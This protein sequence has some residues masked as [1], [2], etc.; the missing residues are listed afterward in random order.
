MQREFQGFPDERIEELARRLEAAFTAINAGLLK[1]AG[2]HS[3]E[4]IDAF[5]GVQANLLGFDAHMRQALSEAME[6]ARVK[7]LSQ[8]NIFMACVLSSAVA[9]TAFKRQPQLAS[10][11]WSG[12]QRQ[13]RRHSTSGPALAAFVWASFYGLLASKT[14]KRLQQYLRNRPLTLS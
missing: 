10:S 12:L 11:R 5:V 8:G 7:T 4:I 9:L 13:L 3:D 2:L 1:A 6:E 14:W